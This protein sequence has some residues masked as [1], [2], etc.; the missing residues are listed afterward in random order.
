MVTWFALAHHKWAA[1]DRW[2]QIVRRLQNRIRGHTAEMVRRQR[3]RQ[4]ICPYSVECYKRLTEVEGDLE[5][6][7]GDVGLRNQVDTCS[8]CRSKFRIVPELP[9]KIHVSRVKWLAVIPG[10]TRTNLIRPCLQVGGDV[11]IGN[12]WN[13]CR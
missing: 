5:I 11:A 1:G 3:C 9:G 12:R 2:I 13:L 7:G 6:V 4:A 10:H 8:T